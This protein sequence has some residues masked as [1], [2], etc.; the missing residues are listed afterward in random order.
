MRELTD[1]PQIRIRDPV[2]QYKVVLG[3]VYSLEQSVQVSK[4]QRVVLIHQVCHFLF[5]QEGTKHFKICR[6]SILQ[7]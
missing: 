2:H 3:G 6:D 5:R 7:I 1:V 4:Y